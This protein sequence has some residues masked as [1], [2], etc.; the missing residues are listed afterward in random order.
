MQTLHIILSLMGIVAYVATATFACYAF[1]GLKRQE[2]ELDEIKYGVKTS[3]A[4]AMGEHL[5]NSFNEINDMKETLRDM[6]EDERF[7]EAER[8]KAVIEK[9]ESGAM[10]ELERFREHFGK[11]CVDVE[12]TNV[13]R[14]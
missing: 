8:L 7:E 5:R 11:D 9:A 13:R 2:A 12:I 3:I 6:V 14:K 4:L 1:G 10:R